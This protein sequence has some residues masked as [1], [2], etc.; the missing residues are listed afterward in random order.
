MKNPFLDAPGAELAADAAPATVDA[1]FPVETPNGDGA[2][3]LTAAADDDAPESIL[4][5][6]PG[7]NGADY[8]QNPAWKRI[9]RSRDAA[10]AEVAPLKA[11]VAELESLVPIAEA[12]RQRFAGRGDDP[13]KAMQWDATFADKFEEL[14]ADDPEVQ[15]VARKVAAAMS[16]S[17]T[18]TTPAEKPATA[19]TA[20][21]PRLDAILQRDARREVETQLREMGI[22]DRRVAGMA[23]YIVKNAS[24]LAAIS[25]STVTELGKRYV[26]ENGFTREELIGGSERSAPRRP[27][28]SG[29]RGAPSAVAAAT[30]AD[31]KPEPEFKDLKSYKAF[32]EKMIRSFP[33]ANA[34]S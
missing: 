2:E 33:G 12:V 9:V 27:S 29:S 28:T 20:S 4:P 19:A 31:D 3:P 10:V 7:K 23:Q 16:G 18:P 22:A 21:D 8:S 34:G 26:A 14:M 17:P 6:A 15:S 25:E 32:K 13:I 30:E 11:K 5:P 24:D 1:L